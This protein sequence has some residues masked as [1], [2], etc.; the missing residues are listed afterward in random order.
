MDREELKKKLE[1]AQETI[2]L[3]N[4]ELL[5][6]NQG[7]IALA[8]E[9]KQAEEK[10]KQIFD[11][12]IMGIFQANL[13]NQ[14]EM[15][16]QAM[17][18]LLGYESPENLTENTKNINKDIFII[19]SQRNQFIERLIEK[20]SIMEFES[21]VKSKTGEVLWITENASVIKNENEDIIGY[22]EM[23]QD[24]T[25]RKKM[26]KELARKTKQ[27]KR[28][29]E[30]LEQSNKDLQQF[31]YVASHDLQEPLRMVTS[32]VQLLQKRYQDKLDE[33][34]NEF[35][36]YAV[37][38]A[39]RMK[40]LIDDLLLLSRVETR[41]KLFQKVNMNQVLDN[42]LT[43]LTYSIKETNATITND[44]LPEII[45]D[46]TQ[47]RTILQNLISNSLKF[48]GKNPPKIHIS[49]ETR[50]KNWI[51]WVKDNGIGIDQ[52]DFNRIFKIFQRLHTREEFEGTGIGLA[53]C[54]K[55]IQRHDGEIWVESEENKGSIFY[56]SIPKSLKNS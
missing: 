31:A 24:I 45:A 22:E 46:R 37:E 15:V 4:E 41:G 29:N 9:L 5:E 27:L 16:N 12:S 52:S 1:K 48:H 36:N 55:I 28:R 51:F 11:N 25:E 44:P 53:L 6:A 50:E 32:F 21:K 17:A 30:D 49:G 10:Y 38:G 33:E 56:F 20:G 43:D 47:M 34:A 40:E 23:V 8:L 42:V 18:D 26:E 19:T 7:M 2:K 54:K 35:I 14:F 39:Q 3:L 13:N